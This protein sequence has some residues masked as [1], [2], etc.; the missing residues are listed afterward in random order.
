MEALE[1]RSIWCWGSGL[2][3]AGPAKLPDNP[4]SWHPRLS[5]PRL[6]ARQVLGA[7]I[8]TWKFW[9]PGLS[10]AGTLGLEVHEILE[11][12]HVLLG[13]WAMRV[14]TDLDSKKIIRRAIR[15]P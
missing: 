2:V 13:L 9:N 8:D 14:Q 5:M 6:W 3:F 15:I 12:K 11:S 10:D 4:E 1:C 7:R